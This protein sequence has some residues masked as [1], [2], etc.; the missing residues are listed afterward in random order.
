MIQ[1]EEPYL[2]DHDGN[3]WRLVRRLEMLQLLHAYKKVQYC[4]G[5]S[6]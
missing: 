1:I 6:D 4:I 2:L 5:T 3:V